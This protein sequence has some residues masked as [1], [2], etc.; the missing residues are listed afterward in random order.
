MAESMPLDEVSDAIT[1]QAVSA[2]FVEEHP[3][4]FENVRA[5]VGKNS[6]HTIRQ[7]CLAMEQMDL[8]PL[9]RTI[10][11]PILFTNGTHD[12]MTPPRLAPSGF[13]AE[14]VCRAV[15]EWARLHEFPAIGHADLLECPEEAVA[16]V[17]AFFEEV[18]ASGR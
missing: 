18:V 10:R 4:V 9:A 16:V 3:D 15:P 7:A 12:I 8:E 13:S 2:G 6:L 17:T 1:I 14:D 11:R 5:I